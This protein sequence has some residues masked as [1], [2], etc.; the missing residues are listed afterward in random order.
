MLQKRS[1][2]QKTL[3]NAY[4][5]KKKTSARQHETA[6]ADVYILY[7]ECSDRSRMI[8]EDGVLNRFHIISAPDGRVMGC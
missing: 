7:M 2:R 6:C 8:S 3:A 1:C 4:F 5:G